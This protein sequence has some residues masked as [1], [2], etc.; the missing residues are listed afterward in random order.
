MT[1]PLQTIKAIL[2]G[3]KWSC[4]LLRI[5]RQDAVS[6]VFKVQPTMKLKAFVDD[7]KLQLWGMSQE[8]LQAVLQVVWEL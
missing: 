1:D 6:E 3:S 8:V 2:Q 5:V 4:L 7:M